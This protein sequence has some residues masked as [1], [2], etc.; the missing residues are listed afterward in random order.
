MHLNRCPVFDNN[1]HDTYGSTPKKGVQETLYPDTPG[2][3]FQ[4]KVTELIPTSTTFTSLTLGTGPESE[5]AAGI[6]NRIIL[7]QDGNYV[8]AKWAD[9]KSIVCQESVLEG[10]NRK[11]DKIIATVVTHTVT[12]CDGKG[13]TKI[14]HSQVRQRQNKGAMTL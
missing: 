1:N 6:W 8:W 10:W 4:D 2:V 14:H 13:K 11:S 9:L 5:T 3:F 12:D 7:Q